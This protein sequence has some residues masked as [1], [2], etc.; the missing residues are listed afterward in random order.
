MVRSEP[1]YVDQVPRREA[2]EREHPDVKITCNRGLW[3]AVVPGR[4]APVVQID[5]R[6]LL[7]KLTEVHP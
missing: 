5:L 2:Y 7:D 6:R 4:E 1:V 3:R